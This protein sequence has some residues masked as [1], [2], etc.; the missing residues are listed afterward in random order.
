MQASARWRT[1][2]APLS[3]AVLFAEQRQKPQREADR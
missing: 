1:E 3:E 2:A